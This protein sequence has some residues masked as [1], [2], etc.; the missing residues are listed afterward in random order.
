MGLL[1]KWSLEIGQFVKKILQKLTLPATIGFKIL[2]MLG[3]YRY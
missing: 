3:F 2:F 1:R